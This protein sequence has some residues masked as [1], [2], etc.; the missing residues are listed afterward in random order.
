MNDKKIA[1]IL[2]EM[3]DTPTGHAVIVGIGINLR[4]ADPEL[5]ATSIEAESPTR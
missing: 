4:D 2:S 3:V 1:G 5:K